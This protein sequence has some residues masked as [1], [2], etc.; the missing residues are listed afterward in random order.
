MTTDNRSEKQIQK[1]ILHVLGILGV[2]HTV[3]DSGLMRDK[4][5]KFHFQKGS[6]GWT[7]ISAVLPDG[8]FFG[9]EVKSAKGKVSKEQEAMHEWLM[10]NNAIIIVARS[11]NEVYEFITNY[12]SANSRTANRT[13]GI[14]ADKQNA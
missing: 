1:D 5:G 8:K 13:S 4:N 11:A 9:I 12:K 7:D 3:S 10:N 2:P 14:S 6:T